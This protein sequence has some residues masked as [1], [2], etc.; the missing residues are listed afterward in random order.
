[1]NI[2]EEYDK[3]YRYCWFRTQNRETAEDLTQETFLRFF[4]SDYREEGKGIRYLYT[5]A[6]NLC[7]EA[8]RTPKE[9]AVSGIASYDEELTEDVIERIHI[10]DALMR[11]PDDDRDILIMRFMNGE[12]VS[13]LCRI[14]GLS[15]FQLYRRLNR[16][17]KEFIA[18]LEEETESEK[19]YKRNA[20]K[21]FKNAGS[22]SKGQVFKGA[23]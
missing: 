7:V 12:S 3:I 19:K 17:K 21:D 13:D 23:P 8:Y 20:A 14:T 15:R 2:E 10:K 18:L 1:M 4:K 5:I 16:L 11:L 9:G 22:C 6:R